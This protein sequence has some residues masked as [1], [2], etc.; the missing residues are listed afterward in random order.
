MIKHKSTLAKLLAKENITVQYGNYKTAWFDIKNRVLGIPLWKDMGKDVADLFIGHEV[1]HALF[2]PYEGWHD[3]P[4]K[5]EGCPRT[6]INVIEDARI[7]RHIKDAY[8]GLVAPMARGYKKLFDDNFFGVDE[9]LDWDQV[10]LIDKINLK[11]KV[12]AHLEVPMND[13][14]MVY[15][16]RSMKTETFD[17]VLDLVRDILAYTKENQ[18]ELMTPPPM[19]SQDKTEGQEE[20]DDMSPTGHDDMESQDEQTKDTGNE[21]QDPIDETDEEG[22]DSAKGDTSESND[23]GNDQGNVEEQSQPDEDVSI[24]DESFRRKEHTLLDINENGSQTLIGNEFSKPVRDAIITPY[25][26]LK[27]ARQIKLDQYNE[28]VGTYDN[29]LSIDE[30]RAEFKQYLKTVKQNVNFAVKEFEMRKAAFRYTRAQTAKTGSIDVNRLWSYKTNDDIFARVTKLADAKN[31]GMMMLIDYSGSMSECMT[32]VMDQLLHLVVFC[33][34]VNIPFDVY[35]FTNSNPRLSQWKYDE[36]REESI[37]HSISQ[38]ESEIHHGGL[39]LPQVIASTLKKSDYEEALFHIY[40]RKILAK[41]EWGFYERY[42]LAQQ[43]EYGSTPL[44]QSLIA[45]HRMVDKFKRN[46]NIDNMNFVVISDGD[47]NGISIVKNSKRDYTLTETYKG[48]LVNIMGEHV[49]LEDT[50]K[51]GTQSL[52][53]S[54]QKKFGCTTIGFFLA[55]SA[56]NFKYK[57]EDCDEETYYDSSNMRKYQKEYNK[58]K[59]VTFTDTL[60]Y[61]EFYVL[62]SKRLETDAEEFVTAEDAS[63]GQLTT[64][65]KKF[66]KS[67]KLNKTL[68]TNF[69]KAVAE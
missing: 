62:K 10:K 69:G 25:A 34:A 36:D 20:N 2:T 68:L 55:D 22:K 45:A 44:N 64:A 53:E 1:G 23:D 7:E 30:H 14:E 40:L 41:K 42:V 5:L 33:K 11:A 28:A 18:E 67:K 3:S 26:D 43:E 31:H 46:N 59:C 54:L 19:G 17:E 4:E 21:Q 66:S 61:N 50:R 48:A 39:S 8:V 12:G 24:T 63:K 57:I 35:G 13:E 37:D 32:N 27:K 52:L 16:N 47:T 65:F 29:M 56:H 58:K 60:G 49:K 15:Y 6:Y 38:I 51:R 9:D